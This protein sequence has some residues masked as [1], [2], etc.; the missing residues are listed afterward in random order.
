MNGWCKM[1]KKKEVIIVISAILFVIALLVKVNLTLQLILMLIAYILVGK[2]TV[3]GA[4][5]NF[6]SRKSPFST[7]L[8]APKTDATCHEHDEKPCSI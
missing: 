3:L 1:K 2:D 7:F 5:K 8:I 6:S 4:I